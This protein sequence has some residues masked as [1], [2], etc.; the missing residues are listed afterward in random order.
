MKYE[1]LDLNKIKL[2]QG[3]GIEWLELEK[4]LNRDE[5]K[6]VD[7]IEVNGQIYIIAEID[8]DPEVKLKL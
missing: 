4:W 2:R 8:D 7:H 6:Y 1:V 5:R 3:F